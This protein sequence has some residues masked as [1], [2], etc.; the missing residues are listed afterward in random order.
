MFFEMGQGK[1]KA[2]NEMQSLAK[3]GLPLY[4]L[5]RSII[6]IHLEKSRDHFVVIFSKKLVKLSQNY[7]F[8]SNRLINKLAWMSK[9]TWSWIDNLT[10]M[11]KLPWMNKPTWINKFT[12]INIKST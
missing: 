12:R 7:P 9:L 11:N 5:C 1:V 8:Y 10:W 6:N 3:T 2:W 4:I